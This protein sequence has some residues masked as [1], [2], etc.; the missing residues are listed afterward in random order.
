MNIN[1]AERKKVRVALA[2]RAH[3]M[4]QY[5]DFDKHEDIN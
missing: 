3:Q 5:F 2:Q 4:L 1:S